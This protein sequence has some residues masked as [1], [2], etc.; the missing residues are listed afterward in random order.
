MISEEL[1]LKMANAIAKAE[2]FGEAGAVQT[3]AHNPGDLTDDGDLGLGV[4]HTSGPH[5]AAITIYA[6]DA[7]G[8]AALYRKVRRMLS[9]ASHTY[10]LN[11]TLMECGLKWSGDPSWSRNVAAALGFDPSITLAAIAADDLKRQGQGIE[12]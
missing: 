10:T 9:G 8:W 3:R 4:I 6:T 1:I 11:L 12:A 2:G 7:D 5:G